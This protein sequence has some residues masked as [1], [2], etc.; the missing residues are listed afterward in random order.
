MIA[1]NI[2]NAQQYFSYGERF[3]KALEYLQV[4]DFGLIENG[5][6]EL[7]GKNIFAIVSE[8]DTKPMEDGKWESHKKYYDVQFVAG[9]EEKIGYVFKDKVKL[10]QE[11][12]ADNDFML[13][14][15]EG[16]FL[17]AKQGDFLI[18]GP[19]DVHMPSIQINGPSKVKKVV[20][21]VLI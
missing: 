11:Y 17:T 2:K 3:Q 1:D 9:G 7:D 12:N 21:K 14:E 4:T 18:L 15:G 20:V 6:H 19:E 16:D 8:Y 13:W 10:L 5:T